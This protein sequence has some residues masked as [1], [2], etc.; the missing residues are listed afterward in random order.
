MCHGLIG[1]M[2]RR[3]FIGLTIGGIAVSA[4]VRTWPFRVYSFPSAV[5]LVNSGVNYGHPMRRSY[6]ALVDRRL[7]PPE[8]QA[9]LEDLRRIAW[10]C[11]QPH[12][13]RDQPGLTASRR[14]YPRF[15]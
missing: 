14:A 5:K 13:S 8:Q 2:N 3:K 4:A 10:N 6:D 7:I 1:P 11:Q 15:P 9:W 12:L